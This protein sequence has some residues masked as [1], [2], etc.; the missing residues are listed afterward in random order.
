VYFYFDFNDVEKQQHEKMIGSLIVQLSTR[1][2]STP[3]ALE[4]LFSSCMNGER[5]PTAE[6]LLEILRHM[7]Q[8]FDSIFAILDAL[9]ECKERL[10]LLEDIEEM[11]G[12]RT[13]KL[14]MLATSRREKDIEESLMPLVSDKDT[15]CIQSAL[16]NSDIRA[17]THERLQTDRRLKR[18]RKMP[19]V[20]QE[21]EGALVGK[22]DGM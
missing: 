18:W 20:Q 14:H 15:I 1:S 8:G 9:D 11:T 3:Q 10:E 6:A 22:A 2:A 12:W 13:G 19:E 17:Y 4:S 21:L 7:L 16:V 5:Q